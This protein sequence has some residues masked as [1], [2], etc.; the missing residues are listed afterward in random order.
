MKLYELGN[1]R[2]LTHKVV[3]PGVPGLNPLGAGSR[4]QNFVNPTSLSN[5]VLA[6]KNRAIY[7]SIHYTG[8]YFIKVFQDTQYLLLLIYITISTFLSVSSYGKRGHSLSELHHIN[9]FKGL[10][11]MLQHFRRKKRFYLLCNK[12]RK[13]WRSQHFLV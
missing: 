7:S 12:A 10:I 8:K 11:K 5:V 2:S 4:H 3:L 1:L 9:S 13:Y 6:R